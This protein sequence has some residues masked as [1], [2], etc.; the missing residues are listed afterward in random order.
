MPLLRADPD[1]AWWTHVGP[2]A[3][4]GSFLRDDDWKI[5]PRVRIEVPGVLRKD[6]EFNIMITQEA[7]DTGEIK[8]FQDGNLAV[9]VHPD[10][11]IQIH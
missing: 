10:G 11:E 9:T 5:D 6:W 2:G 7:Y 4:M 1:D 8:I 3:V